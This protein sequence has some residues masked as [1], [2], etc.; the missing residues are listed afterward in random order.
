[1]HLFLCIDD[2]VAENLLGVMAAMVSP[3]HLV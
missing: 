3:P 1:M 2:S